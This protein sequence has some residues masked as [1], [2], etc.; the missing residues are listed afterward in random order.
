MLTDTFVTKIKS[1][2]ITKQQLHAASNSGN[3]IQHMMNNTGHL[4]LKL[5]DFN[6][7]NTDFYTA[8]CALYIASVYRYTSDDNLEQISKLEHWLRNI[9]TLSGMLQDATFSENPQPLEVIER[10]ARYFFINKLTTCSSSQVNSAIPLFYLPA[11]K[12]ILL[13]ARVIVYDLPETHFS[14]TLRST[15]NASSG[16][17]QYKF[18]G[19]IM[20]AT[21]KEIGVVS[22]IAM[23]LCAIFTIQETFRDETMFRKIKLLNDTDKDITFLDA[24]T[25]FGEKWPTGL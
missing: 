22:N 8:I 21:P 13:R 10:R 18:I 11:A 23:L 3:P 12:E 4:N 14:A 5:S 16:T 20:K 9:D 7:D 1:G 2:L 25:Y 17:A 15:I 19:C 6:R 24:I